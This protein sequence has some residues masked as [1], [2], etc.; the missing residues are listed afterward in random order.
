MALNRNLT[1]LNIGMADIADIQKL[2]AAHQRMA[3]LLQ[4]GGP[5]GVLN[6]MLP[7]PAG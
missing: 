2:E 1:R 7:S 6:R 3:Q 5:E 4:G